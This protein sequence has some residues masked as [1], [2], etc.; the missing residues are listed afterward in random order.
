MLGDYIELHASTPVI[1][2]EMT[3]LHPAVGLVLKLVLL[4]EGLLADDAFVRQLK[5]KLLC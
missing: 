5:R 3:H 4:S 1:T 2:V